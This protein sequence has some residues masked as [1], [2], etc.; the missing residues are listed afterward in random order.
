[1]LIISLITHYEPVF[2]M[3][4]H[5]RC[6]VIRIINYYKVNLLQKNMIYITS[7]KPDFLIKG[8]FRR[9]FK[10][11]NKKENKNPRLLWLKLKQERINIAPFFL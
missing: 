5:N 8:N 10:I 1:M 11:Q 9:N 6:A 3:A 2:I 4:L 7:Q